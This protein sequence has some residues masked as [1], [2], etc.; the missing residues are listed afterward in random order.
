MYSTT[1]HTGIRISNTSHGRIC[2]VL[3]VTC[4]VSERAVKCGNKLVMFSGIALYY[5]DAYTLVSQKAPTYIVL[6]VQFPV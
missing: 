6:L 2:Q 5:D 1:S 4:T 3:Q